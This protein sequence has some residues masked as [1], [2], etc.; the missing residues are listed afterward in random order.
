MVD[1]TAGHG[2]E[3]FFLFKEHA[4]EGY[5]ACLLDCEAEAET[6]GILAEAA[7]VCEGVVD[8]DCKWFNEDHAA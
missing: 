8:G 7:V 5:E 2:G 1:Q 6:F 4:L 3:E